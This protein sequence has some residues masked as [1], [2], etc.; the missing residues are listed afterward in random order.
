[1][2]PLFEHLVC[3][4][5]DR[6]Q[7][8]ERL[9]DLLDSPGAIDPLLYH[10]FLA[11]IIVTIHFLVKNHQEQLQFVFYLVV[12]ILVNQV[13]EPHEKRKLVCRPRKPDVINL[14]GE[15]SF[16]SLYVPIVKYLA[17][18]YRLVLWCWQGIQNLSLHF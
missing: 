2:S 15:F 16:I 4:I 3:L 9:F 1:M 11:F 5:L 12:A 6:G 17:N 7:C 14:F 13:F 8:V 10:G 18:V